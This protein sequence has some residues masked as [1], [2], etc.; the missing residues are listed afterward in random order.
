MNRML[1]LFLMLLIPTNTL[2]AQPITTL[3]NPY[4]QNK[5]TAGEKLFY[6]PGTGSVETTTGKVILKPGLMMLLLSDYDVPKVELPGT[7][8][9]L[10]DTA[11]TRPDTGMHFDYRFYTFNATGELL[12][13]PFPFDNGLDYWK[14]GRRRFIEG[15]KMGL[16]NRFGQRIVPAERYS[17]VLPVRKGYT[18][19]C[20]NC[21]FTIFDSTDKEH[22]Y[23]WAG[24]Q[25]EVLSPDGQVLYPLKTANPD[26]EATTLAIRRQY[27]N[28]KVVKRLQ[29]QLQ[30]LPETSKS[31]AHLEMPV[32]AFHYVCYDEPGALSP[33]YHFGL[34]DTAGNDW[35]S[36]L[37]FLVSPDGKQI[38]HLT[39]ELE[40]ITPYALWRKQ[41]ED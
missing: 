21:V 7:Y 34:E 31:I 1:F 17:F 32:S 6:V 27:K 18:I 20:R 36:R 8:F 2:W 19:G 12:Y 13:H 39:P 23:S 25:Y 5:N 40:K 30:K 22:G 37:Q 16:I 28:E 38:L 24:T 3:P 15:E 33:Y 35:G 14:E 9:D 10:M 4:L 41:K 26:S 29:A 11:G